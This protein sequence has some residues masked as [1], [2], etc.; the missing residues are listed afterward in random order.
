MSERTILRGRA[1]AAGLIHDDVIVVLEDGIF[2]DVRLVARYDDPEPNIGDGV[3]VPGFLDVHVHGGAGRDFMDGTE[4]A[5][6]AVARFHLRQGTTALAATTLSGSR[7]AIGRALSAAAAV[8]RANPLDAAEIAAVHLEGPYLSRQKKGAQDE[9]SLRPA[10]PAEVRWWRAL[11]PDLRWLMTVAPEIEGV[12]GLI[13][14][15]HDEICFSLGHTSAT[16]ADCVA[17][18]EAGASHVTHL[19]NAM[20]PLHHRQPGLVGAAMVNPHVTVELIADGIHLHPA[21]LHMVASLLPDRA[22]LVTDAMRACGMPDG[23]FRL[24]DYDVRVAEGA[25]R[26]ADGTLAG[27]ILTMREAVR[28]MVELAGL[29]LEIVLPLATEVPARILG[30]ARRKGRIAGGFDADLLVLTPRFEAAR[31]FRGGVEVK[32]PAS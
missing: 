16:Y 30:L 11:A 3:M 27:S 21:L 29:P 4:E 12:L 24:Y 17:A 13:E 22:A 15:F 19:F 6:H 2:A 28:N 18:F 25:A 1:W 31:V 26:L 32:D 7:E 23:T 5:A 14:A 8:A 10:D 9:A 20:P